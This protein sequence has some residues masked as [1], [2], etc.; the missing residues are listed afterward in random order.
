MDGQRNPGKNHVER[1]R[2]LWLNFVIRKT[3]AG[4]LLSRY[5][6]AHDARPTRRRRANRRRVGARRALRRQS[7]TLVGIVNR[8]RETC[9]F[10]SRTRSRTRALS[11]HLKFLHRLTR[12]GK[13][14]DFI[15]RTLFL[16]DARDD[17]FD[18]R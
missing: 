1:R 3:P 15:Q 16:A 2:S 9:S 13:I 5:A 7:D 12:E 18:F 11:F 6:S 4:A 17:R 14:S 8:D 10:D